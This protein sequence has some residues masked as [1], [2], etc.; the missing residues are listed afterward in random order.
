MRFQLSLMMG[1]AFGGLAAMFAFVITFGAYLRQQLPVGRIWR[2]SLVMAGMAFV[3][4]LVSTL[5]LGYV[6]RR[7][8]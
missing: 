8:L 5:A 6:L 3:I 4:F 2:E 1:L 7:S